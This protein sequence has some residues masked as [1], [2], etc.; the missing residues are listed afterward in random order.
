[1]EEQPRRQGASLRVR[2]EV[3]GRVLKERSRRA[4]SRPAVV[5]AHAGLV[6]VLDELEQL[7]WIPVAEWPT[8]LFLGKRITGAP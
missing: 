6:R 1:M 5:A 2:G 7:L 8:A 3:V 4:V